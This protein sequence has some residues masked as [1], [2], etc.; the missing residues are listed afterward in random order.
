MKNVERSS[1]DRFLKRVE[2]SQI[3][4]EILSTYRSQIMGVAIIWIMLFHG[5]DL[6]S[7]TLKGIPLLEAIIKRG[8]MGVEMFLLVSGIGLFFSFS[9]NGNTLQFY[10]KRVK[11][12]VIPYLVIAF[13]FWLWQDVWVKKD[14]GKFFL[15]ISLVSF[16]K[17][18]IRTVWYVAFILFIYIVYP[19]VFRVFM[20]DFTVWKTGTFMT[21][22]LAI[23]F[24]VYA[25]SP[26][27][28]KLT[29]IA[30]WRI[31]SFVL[32]S[33]LAQWVMEKHKMTGLQLFALGSITIVVI[34]AAFAL[35]HVIG[36]QGVSRLAYL[37]LGL[38]GCLCI[39]L[40]LRLLNAE[41]LNRFLGGAGKY[42]FEIY[43]IHIFIKTVYIYYAPD[44]I[45]VPGLRGG[46]TWCIIMGLSVLLS[47][48]V[49][50]GLG[51]LKLMKRPSADE[52]LFAE[53]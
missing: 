8:M 26:S 2:N 35:N 28:F 38:V 39:G 10:I 18:G 21:V 33:I 32:G 30:L 22:G 27:Y 53:G 52:R 44:T 17:E 49:H 16:W 24:L 36:I 20:K 41:W 11:R 50:K 7:L 46:V 12:V 14:I 3:T 9:K 6:Y 45:N 40:M 48:L 31:S 25:V 1:E 47:V 5:N 29:E 13:P 34:A 4:W 51:K 15:D 43:L 19:F 42:S 23:P 37:P